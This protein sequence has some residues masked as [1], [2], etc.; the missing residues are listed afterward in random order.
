MYSLRLEFFSASTTE[1]KVVDLATTESGSANGLLP[2]A[3]LITPGARS[4]FDFAV[5]LGIRCQKLT[6]NYFCWLYRFEFFM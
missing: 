5:D 2:P 1:A 3:T 6:S 4:K